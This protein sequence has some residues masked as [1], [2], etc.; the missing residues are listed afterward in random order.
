MSCA[1]G[2]PD[3]AFGIPALT[4]TLLSTGASPQVV[5]TGPM[6]A[7]TRG[8]S[9]GGLQASCGPHNVLHQ[10]TYQRIEFRALDL[11]PCIGGEKVSTERCIPRHRDD[12]W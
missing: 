9:C 10:W 7:P 4:N 8:T 3:V 12:R 11:S 1:V 5:A 6:P 2:C